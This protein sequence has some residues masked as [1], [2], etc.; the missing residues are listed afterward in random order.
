MEVDNKDN[1]GLVVS[2]CISEQLE[3]M[4]QEADSRD[5]D[6]PGWS[7]CPSEQ[8]SENLVEVDNKDNDVPVVS[9]RSSLTESSEET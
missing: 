6:V 4:P 5:N 7:G 9:D 8:L 2:G 3:E 1:D